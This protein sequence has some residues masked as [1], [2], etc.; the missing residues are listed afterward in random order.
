M[1]NVPNANLSCKSTCFCNI[2]QIM[3]LKM[4]KTDILILASLKVPF[5]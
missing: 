4:R 1:L 2:L 3:L 5:Y